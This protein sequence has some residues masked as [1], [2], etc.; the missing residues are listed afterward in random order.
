MPLLED[1]TTSYAH[2]SYNLVT[3]PI[4]SRTEKK[5]LKQPLVLLACGGL[6]RK[7]IEGHS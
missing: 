3:T 7:D 6:G 1:T 5:L 4:E 2:S